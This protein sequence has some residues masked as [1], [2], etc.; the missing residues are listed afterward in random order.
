M[1]PIELS[2]LDTWLIELRCQCNHFAI[3]SIGEFFLFESGGQNTHPKR[4]TQNN[5]VAYFCAGVAL[6]LFGI[7]NA[8]GNQAINWLY[9]INRMTT[10]NH[11]AGIRTNRFTACSD[12]L[13]YLERQDINWHTQ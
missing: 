4:L 5:A 11:D 1:N 2:Q 12:L 3:A 8:D 7:N 10:R 6:E 13:N 9:G